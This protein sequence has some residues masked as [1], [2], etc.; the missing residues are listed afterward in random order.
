MALTAENE[1]RLEDAGLVRFF[2]ERRALFTELAHAA[3]DYAESY[4]NAAN[5]PVRI[6]DVVLALEL[7]L[8]VS[9][10]LETF[11]VEHRLTAEVLVSLLCR[12]DP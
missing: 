12:P 2:E 1:Q 4:V 6:D 9:E 7:A 3:F 10:P 8:K 11:L 5:M